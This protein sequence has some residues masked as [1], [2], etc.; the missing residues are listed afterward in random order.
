[1]AGPAKRV[2]VVDDGTTIRLF[3][4]TILE[5]AG[6]EVEEAINGVEGIER[7]LTGRFDLV[8]VDINMP[9]MDGY[10]MLNRMRARPE[11]R[12]I[13]AVTIS[14]EAAPLDEELALAAGANLYIV[15]PADP[16][17]LVAAARLMTGR[18]A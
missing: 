10:T 2:L 15:K 12:D 7:A 17:A 3:H 11:L 6:F 1:M 4:R 16:E 13:P 18:A 9:Q 5:R 8:L 14:T